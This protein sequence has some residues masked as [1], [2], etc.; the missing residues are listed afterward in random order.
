[1][2]LMERT[3]VDQLDLRVVE[4]TDQ[5]DTLWAVLADVPDVVVVSVQPGPIHPL[6]VCREVADRSP[7]S[8]VIVQAAPDQAAHSYQAL[9]VGAWGC[10]DPDAGPGELHDA[11]EAAARGEAL[12]PARHAAW[13]LRELDDQTQVA[14][15]P[16]PTAERMTAAERTVLHLLAEGLDPEAVADHL[17]VSRRVVGRPA[18]SALTRL[19]HRYRRPPKTTLPASPVVCATSN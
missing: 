4:T 12:L 18:G 15:A 8:R 10:L 17:G 6:Q 19:H 13:V 2:A 7:V 5:P 1:M 9:R 11:A 16:V 14:P 3:P